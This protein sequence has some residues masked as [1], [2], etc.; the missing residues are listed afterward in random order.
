[1][2]KCLGETEY[3]FAITLKGGGK[4]IGEINAYPETGEPRANE[5]A[6]RDTF[7]P[8]GMLTRAK[9]HAFEADQSFYDYRF[10]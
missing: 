6:P 7:S 10:S 8:C 2:K 1:M 5:D 3:Y 4:V 9:G